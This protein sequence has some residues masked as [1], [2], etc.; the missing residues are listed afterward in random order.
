MMSNSGFGSQFRSL[1]SRVATTALLTAAIICCCSARS[2]A[3]WNEDGNNNIHNTNSGNVGIGTTTPSEKL[4]VAGGNVVITTGN[5]GLGSSSMSTWTAQTSVIESLNTGIFFGQVRDLHLL[6]N[7]YHNSGWKYKSGGFGA[8]NYFLYNGAHYWRVGP[9][10]TADSAITWNDAMTLNNSGNLGLGAPAPSSYRLA[11]TGNSE[12]TFPNGPT[13]IKLETS[14]ALGANVG[15]GINFAGVHNGTT[16]T[17]FATMSGVKE[18]ATAGNY[19][20]RLV[21]G[22]RT[23]GAGAVDMTRMVIDSIGQVGIGT[24]TPGYKLHVHNGQINAS[25]GLCISGD[26]KTAWSQVTGTP[27]WTTAGSNIS[28]DTGKVSIGTETASAANMNIF[29]GE[30]GATEYIGSVGY[31]ELTL[32]SSGGT[33]L[34]FLSPNTGSG[35]IWFSSPVSNLAGGIMYMHD[36]TLANSYMR[37]NAGGNVV[38]MTIMGDG[39]VGIGTTDPQS[40]LDVGSIGNTALTISRNDAGVAANDPIGTIQFWNNDAQLTTQKIFGNIQV[41]A[42]SA[43]ATDAAAGYMTF[44]TTGT[45]AGSIPSER[46][47]IDAA[48]NVGIGT[49][50]PGAAYRLDVQGGPIN[51]ALGLCIAGICKTA[52][53]QVGG[54]QWLPSGSN[55]IQYSVG[56]VGVGIATPLYSLDVSGGVNGF[57]AKA[58]TIS[59]SDTIAT[60][61]NNTGIQAIV[62]GNGNVGIGTT[63]PGTK[64]TVVGNVAAEA[65]SAATSGV[66]LVGNDVSNGYLQLYDS[67]R[68][69]KVSLASKAGTNSYFNNG[70]V[71]IGTITPTVKLDVNGNTNV[72][73]NLTVNGTGNIT[74]VGTIEGGNIKAKYQDVA[75]WVPSTHVL[76]AGTVVTLDPTKSNHVE[77]SSKSYDT[78]VAGVISA[79]PGISLGEQGPGKVLVATTGRV[80]IK[81]DASH[82]PIQVGDLLVTSSVPGVAMKSQPIDVG[83]VQIHRPGTLIGK[84]LEPLVSG[85]GEILVLLSLQ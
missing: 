57:R 54:S 75:E 9:T 47:R 41:K 25:G 77:A 85:Q 20:G 8:A 82:G 5:L 37:F 52:W 61:E 43:V 66:A 60:F 58:A 16:A 45:A 51:S 31:P 32:E 27:Q 6:S 65:S 80:K 70:N 1:L 68:V 23:H 30:S 44:S 67:T 38:R 10:G 13:L 69:L 84:A 24:P 19:A 12:T 78:R 28:Y 29:S 74:A 46:M 42:S 11:V 53:S 73:G 18:N 26:C 17:T 62:R 56:K 48:G 81:V 15:P 39:N 49:P 7:A 4:V 40:H 63:T 33:E 55:D 36:A 76:A 59:A 83:S 3:Q 71:G 64:L 34:N 14:N 72:V 21:F 22:T 50:T 35:R 2:Q 79:Q